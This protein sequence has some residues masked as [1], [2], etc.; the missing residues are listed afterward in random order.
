MYI[1]IIKD[2]FSHI[3]QSITNI[4]G[5]TWKNPWLQRRAQSRPGGLAT[6]G[7]LPPHRPFVV[8]IRQ[9]I[10]AIRRGHGE[11][12][13]RGVAAQRPGTGKGTEKPYVWIDCISIYIYIN[14]GFS[15]IMVYQSTHILTNINQY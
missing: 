14:I 15:E 1:H 3:H 8:A 5:S 4:H 13:H 2:H 7:F 12:A 9:P 6:H 11:T 10:G